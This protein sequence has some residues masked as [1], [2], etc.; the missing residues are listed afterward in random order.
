MPPPPTEQGLDPDPRPAALKL[1]NLPRSG[2]SMVRDGNAIAAAMRKGEWGTSTAAPSDGKPLAFDDL[3]IVFAQHSAA[4]IPARIGDLISGIS[5]GRDFY[6][7]QIY[8]SHRVYLVFH[9]E[10]EDSHGGSSSTA[11]AL[12][13]TTEPDQKGSSAR[14]RKHSALLQSLVTITT[15]TTTSE[16]ILPALNPS[17]DLYEM[18]KDLYDKTRELVKAFSTREQTRNKFCLSLKTVGNGRFHPGTYWRR[19]S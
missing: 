15:T 16:G 12:T 19:G 17:P 10:G 14:A 7:R 5:P 4:I 2:D 13:S 11:L 1:N 8:N 9:T 3:R 18:L 6:A